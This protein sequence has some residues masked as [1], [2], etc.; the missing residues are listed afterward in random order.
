MK[1][2]LHT[3]LASVACLFSVVSIAAAERDHQAGPSQGGLLLDPNLV[4]RRAEAFGPGVMPA[5]VARAEADRTRQ[6]VDVVFSHP[7]RLQVD[8]GRR[9]Y[10]GTSGIDMTTSLWQDVSLGGYAGARKRY[11]DVLKQ[12]SREEAELARREAILRGL[13]AWID[14][15]YGRDVLE[16]RKHSTEAAEK[17]LRVAEARVRA[18]TAPPSELALARTVLG[19]ARASV[20]AAEGYIVVADGELRYALALLPDAALQPVG[21]LASSDD[22]DIDESKAILVAQAQHPLV[23]LAQSQANAASRLADVN[24]AVGRPFIGVGVSYTREA[25]GETLLGGGVSIPLPLVSP[26]VLEASIARGHAA[27]GLARVGEVQAH[28]AREIRQAIHERHHAREVRE[29]L[30]TGAV[31]PGREAVREMSRRY[32]AGA[33]DLA[34]VLAARRELLAAEEGYFAAAADVHRADTH[35]EHA[36]GGALPRKQDQ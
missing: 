9:T 11:A 15:R 33:A 6:A 12:Q 31:E 1:S 8:V 34:A 19:S 4:R 2:L 35:L 30:K 21:D 18:G 17:M 14:A 13:L 36:V 27:V 20:L 24:T 28:I 32:E 25:T 22:R 29:E 5:R 7:P 23:L 16:I 10:L 3:I 26:T